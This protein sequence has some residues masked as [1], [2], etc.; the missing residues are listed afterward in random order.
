MFTQPVVILIYWGVVHESNVK[1]M[2]LDANGNQR[3][4][5]DMLI[6]SILVHILPGFCCIALLLI[7]QTV[8]IKRHSSYLIAFGIFYAFSNYYTVKQRGQ[9]LYWFLTWE[10]YT[11]I[12]IITATITVFTSLFYLTA[13]IDEYITGRS[14]ASPIQSKKPSPNI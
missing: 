8:L 4:F 9:P 1:E 11:S 10:D 13:C 6:H 7:N 2:R 3:Y 5:E 14:S 12:I